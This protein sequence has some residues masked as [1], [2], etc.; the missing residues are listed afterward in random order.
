[1]NNFSIKSIVHDYEVEFIDNT[2]DTL[3]TVIKDGDWVII[4]NKINE[5][6]EE[7]K[8]CESV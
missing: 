7:K 8:R 1:M 3:K 2:A 4:D 5:L 6:Q